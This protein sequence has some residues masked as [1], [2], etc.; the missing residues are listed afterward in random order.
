[1]K[2]KYVGMHPQNNKCPNTLST[3]HNVLKVGNIYT[4]VREEQFVYEEGI[5]METGV[6]LQGFESIFN[7]KAFRK[8]S[9]LRRLI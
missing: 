6:K 1:M 7:K 3:G 8:P 2:L 9:L 4:I 5:G